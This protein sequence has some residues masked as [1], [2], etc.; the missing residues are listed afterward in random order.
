LSGS[1]DLLGDLVAKARQG[2]RGETG[3]HGLLEGENDMR[4]AKKPRT[5]A[6]I[7]DL[8]SPGVIEKDLIGTHELPKA[9]RSTHQS[10]RRFGRATAV[11]SVVAMISGFSV[12]IAPAANAAPLTNTSWTVSNNQ[13]SKTGVT[14]SY[15][16]KP[17]SGTNIKKINFVVSGSG[18]AG[19]PAIVKAYG[20]GAGAVVLVGQTITYTVTTPT[21]AGVPIYLEFSGLTNSGTAGSYT[22]AITT[23]DG[24]SA[25][26]DTATPAAVTLAANNT[27]V[28]VTIAKSTTFTI[29]T[30]GFT[31]AMDPSLTALADQSQTVILTVLT[32]A[33]SGYTLSVG[34]TANGLQSG[35]S[36]GSPTIADVSAG[37]GTSL[38]WPGANKFGYTVTGT[39]T[40]LTVDSN[41]SGSK[42][43]GYVAAGEPVASRTN[44]TGGAADTINI[45]N[46]VAIDYSAPTGDYTDTVTYT[47][48]PNYA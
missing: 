17:A 37:K 10:N 1:N 34:D 12:L 46:R 4:L 30:T 20:I 19:T 40:G 8:A 47:L 35:S 6:T 27:A 14:Y 38:A 42:Y 5:N 22:T 29:D 9:D 2:A 24:S 26:I 28:A 32:N 13:V 41:F 31:L 11:L 45:I 23:L 25:N 3:A 15:S 44:P 33:N 18:L 43:A 39:G 36:A 7:A 48:T 16:F 21:S